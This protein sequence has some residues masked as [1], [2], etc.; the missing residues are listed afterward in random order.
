MATSIQGPT[1]EVLDTLLAQ[2][3]EFDIS[4]TTTWIEANTAM[5]QKCPK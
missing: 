3:E 1:Q 2:K 4:L 5:V